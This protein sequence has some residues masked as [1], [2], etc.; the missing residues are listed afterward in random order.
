MQK[1][2]QRIQHFF[3]SEPAGGILL[4]IATFLAILCANLPFL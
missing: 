3:Q 1:L 4:L 2:S